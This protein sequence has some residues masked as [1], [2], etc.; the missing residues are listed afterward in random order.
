M[1]QLGKLTTENRNDRTTN[2][3]ELST[4]E[5]MTIMN[6][7]DSNVPLAVG[8]ELVHITEAVDVIG[9]NFSKGGRLIYIGAGTSGRLGVIDAVECPPTFGT[10]FEM[11]V[12]LIAGG[13]RAFIKAVEGAED[14][15]ELGEQDL[16]EI[17]L[18]EIDTVVGIA[19]SGRTPYVLGA[20]AYAKSVGAH[21]I[22]VCCNKGSALGNVV[23]TK[24]EVEVGPEILTGSTRLKA[25]SA[26]K[27]VLNMLST[28]AMVAIGKTYGNLMV[29]VQ[30]TNKKLVDRGE[31]IIVSA[32]NVSSELAAKTLKESNYNVKNSIVMLLS[33]CTYEE[34]VKKLE[35]TRGFVKK[36]LQL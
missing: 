11:V 17:K 33:N 19:A 5:M 16:M 7:E 6:Q 1:E 34:S 9:H 18:T 22:C 25:G 13:E 4:S 28:G 29:D 30:C 27:M 23:D 32:T 35:A 21:T 15:S 12:G 14:S 36:A 26:Q 24:I 2:I 20:V 8:K 3:D 10:N 31:R